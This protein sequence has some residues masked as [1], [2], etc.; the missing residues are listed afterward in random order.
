MQITYLKIQKFPRPCDAETIV[1]VGI[2]KQAMLL[3]V[4]C[5]RRGASIGL[6]MVKKTVTLRRRKKQNAKRHEQTTQRNHKCSGTANHQPFSL[7]GKV[8]QDVPSTGYQEKL[9]IPLPQQLKSPTMVNNGQQVK[10]CS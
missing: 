9:S 7:P 4:S 1:W 2:K 5:M 10:T 6:C 8:I 3:L